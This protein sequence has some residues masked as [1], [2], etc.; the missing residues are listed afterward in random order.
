MPL[1]FPPLGDVSCDVD[2]LCARFDKVLGPA[3]RVWVYMYLLGKY[4]RAPC[5]HVEYFL[6]SSAC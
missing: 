6:V 2:E 1:L 4:M 5:D 3:V